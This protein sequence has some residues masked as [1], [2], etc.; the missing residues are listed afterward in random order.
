MKKNYPSTPA[1][2]IRRTTVILALAVALFHSFTTRAQRQLLKD[3]NTT[4]VEAY[5]PYSFLQATQNK[6]YL[7]KN[8]SLWMLTGSAPSLV[9]SFNAIGTPVI[10]GDVAYFPADDGS[11]YELWQSDGTQEGTVMIKDIVAGAGGC[12]PQSITVASPTLIYFTANVSPYGRELWRSDGTAAG[13]T[14]VKDLL[15][16]V[17][18]SN[19][20]NLVVMN[21][22]IYFTAN[23]GQHGYELWKSAGTAESTVMVKDIRPAV[24]I[25]SNPE[26][27]T[28]VGN[29]IYFRANEDNQG[30]ELWRS[31][32][33]EAGTIRIKDIRAGTPSSDIEN[34]IDVNGILFFTA[35]DGVHGDELWRSDG[36]TSGT[37]LVKDL[38][39]GA[40]GSN[41]TSIWREPMG[42]FTN[43]NGVLYY[44]AGQ[45]SNKQFI[46]RSDGTD[47]G[48]FIITDAEPIGLNKLQPHFTLLNGSIY[49]LNSSQSH[50]YG[51]YALDA[52]NTV[53]IV[54]GLIIPEDYY[55][56][57][58]PE[59]TS[60]NN[61]LY[62]TAYSAEAW[63]IMRLLP[64]GDFSYVDVSLSPNSDSN[65]TNFVRVN[66]LLYFF[67][68]PEYP[69]Y[70][71]LWRTDG[72][73]EGTVQIAE[74]SDY[75]HEMKAIGDQLFFT[76]ES[77]L[78]VTHCGEGEFELVINFYAVGGEVRN[79]T[80]VNGTLY[81]HNNI[82]ELWKSDGT[83]A[84]TVKVR[85]LNKIKTIDNVAGKAFVLNESASGGLELW[86]TNA[87][88]MLLVKT[89]RTS[90]ATYPMEILTATVGNRLYFV[91]NDGIHGNEIWHSDGTAFGT[92]MVG[93]LNT[94]DPTTN[95][96]ESD[97]K[98]FSVL[99]GKLYVSA[100]ADDGWKVFSVTAKN[101]PVPLVSMPPVPY[102][103]VDEYRLYLF[104]YSAP[105]DPALKLWV[106]DLLGGSTFVFLADVG[107]GGS[108]S[109][110]DV[111]GFLYFSTENYE[112]PRQITACGIKTTPTGGH[113]AYPITSLGADLVFADWESAIGVE[114]YVYKNIAA[115]SEDCGAAGRAARSQALTESSFIAYPNPSSEQF[116]LKLNGVE[117][118]PLHVTVHNASG[119]IIETMTNLNL[120]QEYQNIGA[121]W[122]KGIYFIKITSAGRT[123][124]YRLVKN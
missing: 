101:A 107:A 91:A 39:P 88:G 72:T 60:L 11:G 45:G 22:E 28:R 73:P 53:H 82:G 113:R 34:L 13:T 6:I 97:I 21:N 83:P 111:E 54:K 55:E 85:A 36:T 123:D 64:S 46:V 106:Y 122:P 49:F 89:I 96:V 1:S 40:E 42:N 75:H 19:A 69:S 102:T 32:G 25:S 50:G 20:R 80:D 10:T 76:I 68:Q 23:D 65:P 2:R 104:A 93:D 48:T 71:Q 47:P 92:L 43:I 16:G 41:N 108:I 119:H 90:P 87:T 57:F 56:T 115:I 109:Y 121:A 105:E 95:G 4:Q 110:A 78:Y 12:D 66:N 30:T 120:N 17:G 84:G 37:S 14:M 61:A 5:D 86:R 24:R 79:L 52:A 81:F 38:V 3:I 44:T 114:P 70:P 27:I 98:S 103:I 8:N 118:E 51:V 26:F 117:G 94:I 18:N 116:T 29:A 99:N 100:L 58:E 63:R 112:T 59:M 67:T 31:D 74:L 124:T 7:V 62:L 77:S 15:K 33:T 9:K 35:N